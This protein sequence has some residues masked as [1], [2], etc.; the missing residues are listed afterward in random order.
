MPYK[1]FVAS[2]YCPVGDLIT[3][4]DMDAFAARFAFIEKHV[5]V[6]KVYLETYRSGQLIDRLRIE[7]L[8]SFFRSKGIKTSGGITTT[9]PP[10]GKRGFEAFCYTDPESLGF[11]AD[12]SRFTASLFDEIILDDFYFTNCRCERCIEAKGNRSWADFRLSLMKDVSEKVI[13]GPARSVN[14]NVRLIIKYPNWY[15]HFQETGYNLEDEPA[16]FDMV[17][18]GTETRNP[19]YTTQNLPK[20]LSYFN[21][22]FMENAAPGR[23]GGGWFDPYECQY[24]L[25]SYADQAWLTL[26]SKAREATLFSLGSLLEEN[27][28]LFAPA[29]GQV[30]ADMDKYLDQLGNPVGTA[31]YI[32]FHS[33][34]EDYLHNYLGMAG[35]PLEPFPS[36]PEDADVVFLAESSACDPDIVE[37]IKAGL[38]RGS[39][40]VVTSGFIKASRGKTSEIANITCTDR[41]AR[42]AKYACSDSGGIRFDG[43]GDG[44]REIIIPQLEFPT[45]DVWKLIGALGEDSSFPILLKTYYGRGEFVVL[46]IPDDPGDIYHYPRNVLNL[47]RSELSSGRVTLDSV[48]RHALFTYDNGTFILRSFLPYS[49]RISINVKGGEA[50]LLDLVSGK[51]F[52]GIPRDGGMSFEFMSVPGTNRIFKLV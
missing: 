31:C 17:Y 4:E 2:V 16:I 24:N 39:R 1:N 29:A 52:S 35:I 30:F 22:R 45:N 40:V 48:A 7:S 26:F 11:L 34:G 23:N 27:Y 10:G 49:D 19:T 25:T 37:K 46:T 32:P 14:P 12:V 50:K 5:H 36:Y 6:G 51:V 33:H 28:S 15:E 9:P 20:Y 47:I 21:M 42:V 44:D 8:I 41:K 43:Y 38:L 13:A 3:I 18:T